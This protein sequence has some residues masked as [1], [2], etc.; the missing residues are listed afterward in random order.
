M[1]A[2]LF[3]LQQPPAKKFRSGA[4]TNETGEIIF[5]PKPLLN[6]Y[7]SLDFD[8]KML[9]QFDTPDTNNTQDLFDMTNDF[10]DPL[11]NSQQSQTSTSTNPQQNLYQPRVNYIPQ[12]RPQLSSY[13]TPNLQRIP[14]M[15]TPTIVRPTNVISNGIQQQSTIYTP[16]Q[17]MNTSR[18]VYPRMPNPQQQTVSSPLIRQQY[19]PSGM[20]PMNQNVTQMNIVKAS[21]PNNNSVFVTNSQQQ[22][23]LV[24]LQPQHTVT[25]TNKPISN[26]LPSLNP[27]QQQQLNQYQVQMQQQNPIQSYNIRVCSINETIKILFSFFQAPTMDQNTNNSSNYMLPTQAQQPQQTIPPPPPPNNPSQQQHTEVQRKQFIQKQLVLLLHAHKCQQR[28]KQIINGETRT[29]TCALPHCSTMKNVLQHMTKCNDHKTCPVAHCVTSRQIILHW[30]QCNNPQCPICQPL[31]TPAAIKNQTANNNN[32]STGSTPATAIINKDWQ[33]RVTQEMRN[34]LVQK[35]I[36]ALIPITDTGTMRDK[37]IINLANYARRVESETFEIA[38]NQE[39]YFH[40]LAE[41]IYKIQKELED[42]REK[43]RFQDMQLAA[44]IS[45]TTGQTTSINDFNG[46]IHPTMDTMAGDHGPPNRTAPLT[47]YLS[48][49]A[50]GNLLLQQQQ[51]QSIKSEPL[52]TLTNRTMLTNPNNST[53]GTFA[54]TN[55][56]SNEN[57]SYLLNGDGT[58][59][60]QLH[61]IDM[62]D[63]TTQFKNEPFSP[64]NAYQVCCLKL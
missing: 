46:K 37:R 39:E 32:P 36:T 44:Q 42:R 20:V 41:K 33:R 30:K 14:T 61:D 64:K 34:H 50:A 56:P 25:Q 11:D 7:F 28:E 31:K 40:K 43:K 9:S 18:P 22:S 4:N 8:F 2:D 59:G 24:G 17:M 3:S 13:Q 51:Q 60:S 27:Q 57:L 12:T 52:M 15:P 16:Q 1:M 47:D 21:D 49:S 54:V 29:S 53:L 10:N 5:I 55:V 62:T 35:I 23:T 26:A 63:T 6:H 48:S 45:S 58:S 19:N 38:N